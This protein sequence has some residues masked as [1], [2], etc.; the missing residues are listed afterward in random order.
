M[1][2]A[3]TASAGDYL[4]NRLAV[5]TCCKSGL[6]DSWVVGGL[7]LHYLAGHRSAVAGTAA[8]PSSFAVI[9][10]TVYWTQLVT[11]WLY[12]TLQNTNKKN[13]KTKYKQKKQQLPAEGCH[14]P[15]M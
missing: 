3:V 4:C 7:S 11:R 15:Q 14:L 13:K 2:W 6:L 12:L 9:G 10:R 8:D 1:V 5:F